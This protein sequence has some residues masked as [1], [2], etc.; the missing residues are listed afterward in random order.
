MSYFE[1]RVLRDKIRS[2]NLSEIYIKK[3]LNKAYKEALKD[4]DIEINALYEKLSKKEGLSILKARL[5]LSKKEK[6]KELDK[7][8]KSV[9]EER[10][11]FE[12]IKDDLDESLR[13]DLERNLKFIENNLSKLSKVGYISH[14]EL[15]KI[16]IEDIVL[17]LVNKNQINI[18]EHLK[19]QYQD[20]YFRGIFNLSS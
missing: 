12:D 6:L 4:I 14:L 16:N 15:I 10:D 13:L 1:D 8:S 9:L 11:I 19:E 7:L 2:I 20:G 5:N 18:Y 3:S 17:K